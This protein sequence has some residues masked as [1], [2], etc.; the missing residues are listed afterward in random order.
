M[1]KRKVLLLEPPY[2]NKYPPMGLMKLATYFRNCEDDVRFF[3]GNLK[4]FAVDLLV[5]EYLMDIND[6]N[7]LRFRSF[8]FNYIYSGK[9]TYINAIANIMDDNKEEKLI[10]YRNRYKKEDFPKF[11]IIAITTLFTFYW[12]ETIETINYAKKFIVENGRI[13][14]G[15]I[16]ASILPEQIFKE[17]GIRPISGLLNKPGAIDKDN[18]I[19]IDQLPL[20][21]SILEEIDY[22]YPANDAYFAYMTRGCPN[23]CS[24]C[25]VPQL[26]PEFCHYISIENQI[27]TINQTYG[28]KRSL[29][30]M[31]NNVFASKNFEDIIDEIKRCGFCKDATYT[32]PNEY[33]IAFNNVSSSSEEC[34]RGFIKK[35]IKIYDCIAE[36]LPEDEQGKFYIDREH[37]RLLYPVFATRQNIIEF[38]KIARPL[39]EKH[40]KKKIRHRYVDFNQGVD[41]RLI[42]DEK[43]MKLSEIAIKPLRIAFDHY[44]MKDIYIK[45]VKTAVKYGIKDLSNYLLYNFEDKPEDLYNRMRINVELCEELNVSIYS[46]PM[47][48]HPISDKKYFNNR[49][50]I[51]KH[52]NKKFIRAI[53]AVLNSTKGKIGRGKDFFEEAFGRDVDEFM[54]ILWMPETF[55]IYRRKYDA[56]LRERLSLKYGKDIEG[57]NDLANEWWEKFNTLTSNQRNELIEIVGTNDFDKGR[58]KTKDKSILTVLDYYSIKRS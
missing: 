37:Y 30:L 42:T 10:K 41:A 21:Y 44:G 7:L 33:E 27:R 28:P 35:M 16:A 26:E 53:Q 18:K 3:K 17:T 39:Y 22:Q 11:D 46:F 34:N 43:M 36:K 45:A 49:D 2:N 55:I 6:K 8:I 14:I 58:L 48:Y 5:D 23:K 57:K 32:S 25:A 13:L 24:F 56:E 31:D 54:K 50:F 51:G 52:W 38:D 19:I 1:S 4:K 12:K 40:F 9:R 47:K 29:L 15:G 20:D